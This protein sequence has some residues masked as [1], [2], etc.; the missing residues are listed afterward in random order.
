MEDFSSKLKMPVHCS[1]RTVHCGGEL[2]P[3]EAEVDDE[4][5]GE[6]EGDDAHGREAVAEVAPVTGPEVEHTAGDE[7]KG[8]GVGTG[9]PLAVLDDLAV[10]R[11]DEGGG[12][13]DNPGCGLSAGSGEAGTAVGEGDSG[14]GAHKD[15]DNVDTPK[16]TM[17]FQ[18]T[19][20]DPR[21]E[22]D[23][24]DQESEDSGERVGDEEA[25]V[26][27]DLQTVGVVHGVI[28]DEKNF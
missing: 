11:G 27:D 26:G 25:A 6:G 9:H 21:R 24:A 18:I 10:T 23:G 5:R 19:L 1:L 15:R 28:G 13:A 4:Q 22:I 17:E 8:D 12:G 3:V 7:G 20:A 16:N 2:A 14:R